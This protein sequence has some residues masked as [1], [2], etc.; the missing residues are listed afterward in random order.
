[1]NIGSAAEQ[2]DTR[3]AVRSRHIILGAGSLYHFVDMGLCTWG[4]LTI[5]ANYRFAWL[6]GLN[7]SC[8][9]TLRCTEAPLHDAAK[10]IRSVNST[11]KQAA[12]RS[13]W[14]WLDRY[15]YDFGRLRHISCRTGNCTARHSRRPRGSCH[16]TRGIA[17]IP[18]RGP[19]GQHGK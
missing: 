3:V 11:T 5:E 1:M 4:G 7:Q 10:R 16:Y 13:A 12:T 15:Q 19:P 14:V 6:D 9:A 18:G 2:F 17:D 8:L